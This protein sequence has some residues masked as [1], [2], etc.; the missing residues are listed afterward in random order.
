MLDVTIR[1]DKIPEIT[2]K[3][4]VSGGSGHSG[5]IFPTSGRRNEGRERVRSKA[6][7][8]RLG[9]QKFNFKV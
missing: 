9:Y 6:D 3:K 7:L 5:G 2:F 4:V 8:E 1:I